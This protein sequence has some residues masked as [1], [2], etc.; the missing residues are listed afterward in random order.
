MSGTGRLARFGGLFTPQS[1]PCRGTALVRDCVA[2]GLGRAKRRA[3][4]M[5]LGFVG[6]LLLLSGCGA[7]VFQCSDDEQCG[8]GGTC[9]VD[10]GYCSFPDDTCPS[11]QRYGEHAGDGLAGMCVD[12]GGTT[13]TSDDSSG[14]GA[15]GDS[16][17]DAGECGADEQCVPP[18]P[19][20]WEGP[21]LAVQAVGAAPPCPEGGG[22][23]VLVGNTGL[24]A[25][26]ASCE[27]EC[28]AVDCQLEIYA[29]TFGGCEEQIL[30]PYTVGNCEAFDLAMVPPETT[31]T[32]PAAEGCAAMVTEEI[33]ET[34]WSDEIRLC[35][36]ALSEC[37]DGLCA[38]S[39]MMGEG[40]CVYREGDHACPLSGYT[41]SFT[42]YQGVDDSRACSECQCSGSST[43]QYSA[44]DDS[45]CAGMP[46]FSAT[47]EMGL[48]VSVEEILPA[49]MPMTI[50]LQMDSVGSCE[51]AGIESM[52]EAMPDGPVTL[53]CR[54]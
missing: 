44:Y 4:E 10:V 53:C 46:L 35:S 43:C 14:D 9:Q 40:I 17:G 24:L 52:G 8:A 3:G 54:P 26:P 42:M 7:S 48:C 22:D 21:V 41:Q 19:E 39:L 5:T 12:G 50:G 11:E 37:S 47:L 49:K 36:G 33:P 30:L 45:M 32:A 27:C 2:P 28:E 29:S 38:P 6:S 18:A 13:S 23:S 16:T 1:Y 31:V 51:A 20:G 15:D 25:E 34:S